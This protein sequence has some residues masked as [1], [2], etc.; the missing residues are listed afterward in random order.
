MKTS[1]S[2]IKNALAKGFSKEDFTD[3]KKIKIYSDNKWKQFVYRNDVPK[4]VLKSDF[5]WEDSNDGFFKY[6]NIWYHLSQ[7]MKITDGSSFYG[8][9]DGYYGDSFFSG[10]LI[11]LSDDGERYKV[12]TYIS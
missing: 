4:S 11:K 10:V 12:A 5:D 8:D 1:L 3:E 7:F 2:S 6:R 9:W